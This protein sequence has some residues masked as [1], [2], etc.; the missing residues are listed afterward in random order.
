MKKT[1]AS[2]KKWSSL[3]YL[4]M[5]CTGISVYGQ[6]NIKGT[7][8]SVVDGQVIPGA[9]VIVKGS[10]NGTATDFDG[11]Y[12]I[13]VSSGDVLVFSYLGYKSIEKTVGSTTTINVAL[14]ED[15]EQL[16]DVVVIGYGTAKRSDLTGA[17][18]S[19]SSKDFDKQPLNDVSQALQGRAAGVQVTQNSGAPGGSFK[20]RIRGASSVTGNND[21]L[22]VVDGQF[23]DINT[24]NV[25]DIASMEV[26][27]D[28]SSTA[29]YGTRGANG[30]VLIT[31]KKGRSGKAKIN[32]DVF[33]GISNVTQKL[34]LLNAADFAEGVN[35]SDDDEIFTEQEIED[36]R[37]NG[38]EDW[39]E[40]LFQTGYFNNVQVSASG[41]SENMDY[42]ISGNYYEATGS[43]IDQ[44]FKRLNLRT[45]LNAKLSEKIKVG[46]N[47]NV[48]QVESTGLRANLGVGLSFDP[49]TFAFDEN[50]DYNFNSDGNL[51]TSQTNPLVAVENNTRENTTDRISVNGNFNWDITDNLVFNTSGGVVKSES[52][53]NTYAP[54]ISSSNG[55][56]NVDNIYST[57]LFNTNR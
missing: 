11:N 38:G 41:G 37:A 13:N 3:L 15:A 45:N 48:G 27:K 9:N 44:R 35:F 16:E 28:A 46:L 55:R 36:L 12:T 34:D 14:E 42:Y 47:F 8:T 52:H 39:Q 57:N 54:K 25:N 20:I 50:G 6:I 29:I 1:K 23:V 30:V 4:I 26:L 19:V 53:N 24:I 17:L 40:R 22:Y 10:T 43:V 5:M 18:T 7:V 49:T 51:A 21:P 31:T 2:K 32:V 56:A 33:T